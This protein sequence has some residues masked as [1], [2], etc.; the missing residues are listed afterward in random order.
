MTTRPA[1]PDPRR[2]EKSKA[3]GVSTPASQ[4]ISPRRVQGDSPG[5]D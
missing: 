5:H 4:N 2:R 3:I 1:A